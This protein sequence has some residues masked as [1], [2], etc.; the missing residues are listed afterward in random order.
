MIPLGYRFLIYIHHTAM[1]I[2]L[3]IKV[4]ISTCI[5]RVRYHNQKHDQN[6]V[7]H[8][9]INEIYTVSKVIMVIILLDAVSIKHY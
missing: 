7:Y 1:T 6:I 2:F 3:A 9:Y 8:I 4:N 5:I